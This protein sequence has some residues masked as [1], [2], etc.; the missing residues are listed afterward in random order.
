MS[1]R[2]SPKSW[3]DQMIQEDLEREAATDENKNVDGGISQKGM[4]FES[5]L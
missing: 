2:I 4:S 1:P 5:Q 3:A